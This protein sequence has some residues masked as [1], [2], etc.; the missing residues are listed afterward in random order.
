MR[1]NHA[2]GDRYRRLVLDGPPAQLPGQYIE[3]RLGE[4]VGFFA[5]AAPPATTGLELLVGPG[6]AFADSLRALPVGSE[7]EV[8]GPLGDGFALAPMHGKHVVLFANGSG[9]APIYALAAHLSTDGVRF[10]SL[11][12]WYGETGPDSFAFVDQWSALRGTVH[13]VASDPPHDWTGPTG[14]VQDAARESSTAWQP[15]NTVVAVCGKREM[16][17]DVRALALARGLGD[18]D[19][20]TNL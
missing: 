18:D 2:V 17:D 16:V 1:A 4:E 20:L 9:V 3:A 19:I 13:L 14:H 11:T 8:M 10:R 5:I 7:L 12:V 6:G 15:G